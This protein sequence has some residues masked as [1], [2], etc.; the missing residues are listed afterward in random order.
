MPAKHRVNC[1]VVVPPELMFGVFAN[2]FRVA[3]TD[4]GRCLL[5]FLIYSAA[6]HRA[7]VVGKVPVRKSFLPVIRDRITTC[8]GPTASGGSGFSTR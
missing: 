2:A 7:K 8:L 4:D 6:D 3:D 5:E 1:D